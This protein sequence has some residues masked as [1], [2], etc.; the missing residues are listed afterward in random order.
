[1]GILLGPWRV[2]SV[3]ESRGGMGRGGDRR[4]MEER[5][6]AGE[7]V[8]EGKEGAWEAVGETE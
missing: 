7:D 4:G 5:M 1:M 8:I 6:W 3:G 2:N